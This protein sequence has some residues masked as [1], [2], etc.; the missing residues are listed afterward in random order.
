M[1]VI[2]LHGPFQSLI[3]PMMGQFEKTI[4]F[5]VFALFYCS[6]NKISFLHFVGGKCVALS[7]KES[8]LPEVPYSTQP[9]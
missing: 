5:S 4:Q 9:E 6:C 8:T 1:V 2:Y 7:L 3:T